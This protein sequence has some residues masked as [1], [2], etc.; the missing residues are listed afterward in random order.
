MAKSAPNVSLEALVKNLDSGLGD[1]LGGRFKEVDERDEKVERCFN[2]W[3]K[4][5]GPHEKSINSSENQRGYY[6]HA[7]AKP[8][9]ETQ[10]LLGIIPDT[11]WRVEV[12]H[13]FTAA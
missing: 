4:G 2:C 13:A 7:E 11:W 12:I 6:A 1:W 8:A 9:E 5:K 3:A 10:K